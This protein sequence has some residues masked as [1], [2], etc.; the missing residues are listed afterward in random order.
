MTR[1]RDRVSGITHSTWVGAGARTYLKPLALPPK[2]PSPIPPSFNLVH[3]SPMSLSRPDTGTTEKTV[4]VPATDGAADGTAKGDAAPPPKRGFFARRKQRKGDVP[5]VDD[6]VD[7]KGEKSGKAVAVD[8]KE[9]VPDAV[10]IFQLF[11]CISVPSPL[12]SRFPN[13]M[14]MHRN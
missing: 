5:E 13:F 3:L 11:R 9:K 10:G 6:V 14:K 2:W 12:S 8:D 4:D 7:E 1:V